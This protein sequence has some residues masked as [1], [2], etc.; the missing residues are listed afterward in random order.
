MSLAGAFQ[1]TKKN[2]T[3][4]YRS[5]ITYKNKHIS[6]GSFS[7]ELLAHTA[8]LEAG[9]LVVSADDISSYGTKERTLS[10]E[11]YVSLINFRDHNVYFKN[12]IY[13]EKRYFLYYL[14]TED[15]LKFD[16]DD[17]FYYA[18]RKI[19]KRNGHL[20][21]A[22]YG[23][24]INLLSRYGIKSHAVRNR[25]YRF[26][27]GD[28]YDF[29]YENIEIINRYYGVT[30]IQQGNLTAYKT[31]ILING[32]FTVGVYSTEIE[33]AIAYNKAADY[34]QQKMPHRKYRQNYI[35]SLT[36]SMYAE[37]YLNLSISPKIINLK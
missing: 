5:S 11:K 33:A 26:I 4:Y 35:D 9:Q 18:S 34:I 17:L 21:V 20:F 22:D 12:P 13:L 19:S 1:A 3:N 36:P 14:S 6:L 25:D 24:Q 29:R 27:N 37:L 28:R 16:I 7:T 30:R 15:I 32:V 23:M 8:Y 31:K 2:G 10:F